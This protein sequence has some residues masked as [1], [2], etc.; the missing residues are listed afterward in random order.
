MPMQLA[1]AERLQSAALTYI[2]DFLALADGLPWLAIERELAIAPLVRVLTRPTREEA[3][4]LGNLTH[5]DG[6]G[7]QKGTPIARPP[8]RW[9][10]LR[11]PTRIVSE[12]DLAYWREGYMR[13]LVGEN[14]AMRRAAE[15]GYRAMAALRSLV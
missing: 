13:R 15:L 6:F 10:L 3:R 5:T 9:E 14:R 4:C 2:D 1:A 12:M 11:H 7:A 8:G